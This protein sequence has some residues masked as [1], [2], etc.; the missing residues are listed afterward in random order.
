MRVPLRNG[1]RERLFLALLIGVAIAYYQQVS[2]SGRVVIH[3]FTTAFAMS[4]RTQMA[5]GR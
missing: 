1:P 3:V 4:A 2:S 5:I